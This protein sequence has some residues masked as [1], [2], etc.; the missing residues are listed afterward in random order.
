MSSTRSLSPPAADFHVALLPA[1][2]NRLM[3][4]LLPS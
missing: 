1:D 2:P 4:K 3:A